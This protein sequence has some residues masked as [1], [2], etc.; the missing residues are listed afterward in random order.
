MRMLH[1]RDAELR[2]AMAALAEVARGDAR[3]LALV[4]E[5]GIGKSR[6][7]SEVALRAADAGF[8]GAWG[9]AWEAGGAPAYWPW[10]SLLESLVPASRDDVSPVWGESQRLGT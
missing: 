8:V 1:G 6:L 10:R 9:R 5:P 3:S 2:A 7:A 4:G